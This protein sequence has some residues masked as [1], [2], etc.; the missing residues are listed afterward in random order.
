M[1]ASSVSTMI[2]TDVAPTMTTMEGRVTGCDRS[3]TDSLDA[4]IAVDAD[5]ELP[6]AA[7]EMGT[8]QTQDES[9]MLMN[10]AVKRGVIAPAVVTGGSN[11]AGIVAQIATT[12]KTSGSAAALVTNY[13]P[14]TTV[15]DAKDLKG[16]DA[17]PSVA[18]PNVEQAKVSDEQADS[19]VTNAAGMVD[20]EVS[21]EA[22][23]AFVGEAKCRSDEQLQSGRSQLQSGAFQSTNISKDVPSSFNENTIAVIVQQQVSASA[24]AQKH[25]AVGGVEDIVSTKASGKKHDSAKAD[26]SS[27]TTGAT[28]DVASTTIGAAVPAACEV[29][30]SRPTVACGTTNRNDASTTLTVSKSVAPAVSSIGGQSVKQAAGSVQQNSAHGEKPVNGEAGT[31]SDSGADVHGAQKNTQADVKPVSQSTEQVVK[32]VAKLQG[33]DAIAPTVHSA[34]P[35]ATVTGASTAPQPPVIGAQKSVAGDVSASLNASHGNG[36]LSNAGGS[37]A[38]AMGEV[39][40]TLVATPT[41]LEV[42]IPNGTQGWLKVRAEL[43]NGGINASLAAASPGGQ[44]MLHRELPALTAFLQ[45]EKVAVSSLVVQSPMTGGFR[46]LSGGAGGFAGGQTQQQNQGR[47]GSTGAAF[48]E[49]GVHP[50]LNM[51]A[52]EVLTA[53]QY[54]SG[55]S[56][57]SVRA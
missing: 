55:G 15:T 57:L 48:T 20:G 49:G 43:A 4:Y 29:A 40:K 17:P 32:S 28:A 52:D 54:P 36:E 16:A 14:G 44:E 7:M 12:A 11:G 6:K 31:A 47:A 2:G 1:A 42:G 37:Q 24:G 51:Q 38:P 50:D 41:V 21:A 27:K 53:M 26:V 3:F 39:H 56:W 9:Q 30:I 8:A 34:G 5:V 25:A 22:S 33:A 10:K 46:D 13:Q 35:P 19:V 18:I 23:S 45:Q